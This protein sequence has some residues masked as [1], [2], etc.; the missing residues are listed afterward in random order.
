MDNFFLFFIINILSRFFLW[1]SLWIKCGYVGFPVDNFLAR[2]KLS[3]GLADLST[4]MADLSTK[5]STGYFSG[6][7][8]TERSLPRRG[9]GGGTGPVTCGSM[10]KYHFS[11]HFNFR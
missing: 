9:F 3:T 1:I 2:E 10:T 8:G 5:L 4:E 6:F 7:S 11:P